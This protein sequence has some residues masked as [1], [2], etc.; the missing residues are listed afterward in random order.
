MTGPG[1]ATSG[2]IHNPQRM[3]SFRFF[4]P[5]GMIDQSELFECLCQP[6]TEVGSILFRPF[7]FPMEMY[8]YVISKCGMAVRFDF[9]QFLALTGFDQ[10]P[11]ELFEQSA[12]R[13][14]R[15]PVPFRIPRKVK[16]EEGTM[17][18]C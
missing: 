9:H 13:P 15:P 14:T 6:E 8:A 18:S 12:T 11:K 10:R 7:R 2:Q 1:N 4:N 5:D 16:R 17:A 3:D